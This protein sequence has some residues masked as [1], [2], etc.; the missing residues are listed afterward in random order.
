MHVCSVRQ[1]CTKKLPKR[2]KFARFSSDMLEE[3]V[4]FIIYKKDCF[5]FFASS[6]NKK[7]EKI[8]NFPES[9]LQAGETEL[10]PSSST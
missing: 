3:H 8:M 5:L 10:N 9:P 7:G 1:T 2:E 6:N 4:A